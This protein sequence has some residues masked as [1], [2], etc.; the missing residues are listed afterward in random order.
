MQQNN[1]EDLSS[2]TKCSDILSDK[3]R[4][5][6]LLNRKA[7]STNRA[8]RQWVQALKDYMAEC[9]FPTLD[10]TPNDAL[11]DLLGTFVNS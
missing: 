2:K 7:Q 4:E 1:L 9:N 8:T 10:Q 11:P 6:L 3:D 5:E